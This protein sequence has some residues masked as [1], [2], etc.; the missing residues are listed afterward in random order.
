MAG[1]AADA[2]PEIS[3]LAGVSEEELGDERIIKSRVWHLGWTAVV[4]LMFAGTGVLFIQNAD[5][6]AERADDTPAYMIVV[7]LGA[8]AVGAVGS[9]I[10]MIYCLP[11]MNFLHLKREGFISK[12]PFKRQR[13]VPWKS[14]AWIE[15]EKGH[16]FAGVEVF[17]RESAPLPI[18]SLTIASLRY[19]MLPA[20]I[21]AILVAWRERAVGQSRA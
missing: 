15:V 7:G 17:F 8:I 4:G 21:A 12:T 1:D 18:N 11:G 9:V 3:G 6:I 10:A 14:V 19:G 5:S 16:L 20:D 13:M 2:G